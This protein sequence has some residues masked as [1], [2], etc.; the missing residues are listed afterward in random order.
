MKSFQLSFMFFCWFLN[1]SFLLFKQVVAYV[2]GVWQVVNRFWFI[3]ILS[4]WPS[5]D[6][7]TCYTTVSLGLVSYGIPAPKRITSP[8]VWCSSSFMKMYFRNG[9]GVLWWN[10]GGFCVSGA[11]NCNFRGRFNK[12]DTFICRVMSESNWI[13]FEN[14]DQLD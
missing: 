7:N 3:H 9:V 4:C 10:A 11:W 6:I 5:L 12:W 1:N 2:S 14:C 8:P 13:K